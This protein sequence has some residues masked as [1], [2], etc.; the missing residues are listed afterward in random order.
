M[1]PFKQKNKQHKNNNTKTPN[2]QTKKPSQIAL[3][4]RGKKQVTQYFQWENI[5]KDS[6]HDCYKILLFFFFFLGIYLDDELDL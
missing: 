6:I 5:M 2:K 3:N 4:R 1:M